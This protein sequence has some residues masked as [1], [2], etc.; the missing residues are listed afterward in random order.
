M[1]EYQIKVEQTFY[2]ALSRQQVFLLDINYNF[3][4]NFLPYLYQAFNYLKYFPNRFPKNWKYSISKI[5]NK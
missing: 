1:K 5:T 3:I 2:N 4:S